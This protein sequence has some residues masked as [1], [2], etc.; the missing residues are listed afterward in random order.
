[1][2]STEQWLTLT[3][4]IYQKTKPINKNN[5]LV[6]KSLHVTEIMRQGFT[7]PENIW[8]GQCLD[9]GFILHVIHEY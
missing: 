2:D 1:M 5:D 9:T 6:T 8:S 7:R 4:S 3:I